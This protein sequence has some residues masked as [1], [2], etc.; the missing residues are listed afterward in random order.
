MAPW[1]PVEKLALA[2]ALA[3]ARPVRHGMWRVQSTVGSRQSRIEN[4]SRLVP[5]SP[6][7]STSFLA[8]RR[9]AAGEGRMG[10]Q[11][12]STHSSAQMPVWDVPWKMGMGV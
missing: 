1:L 4:Q 8:A 9:G 10:L 7:P 11:P 12:A 5:A 3:P 6:T 2:L